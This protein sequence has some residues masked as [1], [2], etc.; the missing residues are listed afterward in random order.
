M[1]DASVN[2]AAC[3]KTYSV[4]FCIAIF[5]VGVMV[6]H[7]VYAL[8]N[9]SLVLPFYVAST[10][11]VFAQIVQG[12]DIGH[13]YRHNLGCFGCRVVNELD[14]SIINSHTCCV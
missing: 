9:I 8:S 10:D 11:S 5:A 6:D 14:V 13:R 12:D 7:M 3:C 1:L 2:C 4:V